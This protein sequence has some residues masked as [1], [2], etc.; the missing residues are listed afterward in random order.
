MFQWSSIRATV[1]SIARE[2]RKNTKLLIKNT[3]SLLTTKN[4]NKFI[5]GAGKY[6]M[7]KNIPSKKL[8]PFQWSLDS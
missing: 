6:I 5:N 7:T 4:I 3:H 1:Y 8:F 2:L